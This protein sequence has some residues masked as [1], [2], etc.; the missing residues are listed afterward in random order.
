MKESIQ[1]WAKYN[2]ATD[3]KVNGLL[4]QLEPSAYTAQRNTY[5]KNLSALHL[6]Y[7]QTYKFYQGLIRKNSGDKYFVSPL[8][9]EAYEAKSQS[10]EETAK[11][12][13]E[14][15]KLYL[16][17]S[18]AVCEADLHSP[19]TKRTMRNGKTYLLSIGDILSQYQNH[20]AHHRGQ[21][22]QLLDELGV[23]HDIGGLLV[24]AEEATD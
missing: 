21:L 5:F 19:K 22:S 3:E 20:T 1:L 7:V 13:L 11:L 8:T 16:A 4:A 10:L 24:F 23:E 12:A 18:Q 15:D 17:F 9:E 6:H 14:Y 2:L